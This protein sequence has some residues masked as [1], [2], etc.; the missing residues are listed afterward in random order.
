MWQGKANKK[1]STIDKKCLNQVTCFDIFN[2]NWL[3]YLV[4]AVELLLHNRC[5]G[6]STMIEMIHD[7]LM[8]TPR[9][10]Y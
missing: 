9:R 7:V 10:A 2:C 1:I 6:L 4:H 5:V 8:K 3:W